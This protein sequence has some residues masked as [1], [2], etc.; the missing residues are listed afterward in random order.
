MRV[1]W[2]IWSRKLTP[3]LFK[4]MMCSYP[5]V[6]FPS[7]TRRTYCQGKHLL[8]CEVFVLY[9]EVIEIFDNIKIF[10]LTAKKLELN[11]SQTDNVSKTFC[12]ACVV[13]N[14]ETP[15]S[16]LDCT[17]LTHCGGLMSR[18]TKLAFV[19]K[20]VFPVLLV[21]GLCQQLDGALL[22][23]KD[24]GILVVSQGKQFIIVIFFNIS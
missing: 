15:S 6:S 10:L 8:L 22:Q 9:N 24:K 12:F 16:Q 1:S 5:I 7:P 23:S 4:A 21:C 19:A 3:F 18:L 11:R 13:D 14:F 2:V 17:T 20:I